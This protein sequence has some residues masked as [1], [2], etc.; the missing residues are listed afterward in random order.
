MKKFFLALLF[1]ALSFTL[2][3]AD[4]DNIYDEA[5]L[6]NEQQKNILEENIDALENAYDIDMV[7]L[8][9][10]DYYPGD[11]R[12][13]AAD[14]YDYGGFLSDGLI[15]SI[16]MANREYTIV[17]SGNIQDVFDNDK[18]DEILDA[19]A[20]PMQ[21]GHYFG[22]MEDFVTLSKAALDNPHALSGDDIMMI[23]LSAS[24]CA[25]IIT[26]VFV[27]Y[28][29]SKMRIKQKATKATAYIEPHSF[30]MAYQND[31]FLYSNIIRNRI[32]RSNSSSR[33]GSFRGSSGASHSGG[34]RGF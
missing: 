11:I 13:W 4:G 2:V 10:L 21:S 20:S 19:L 34:S 8:T 27:I 22:A 9:S 18:I 29:L 30:E 24:T 15:L 26:A 31:L 16:N 14:F 28:H 6:L 5:N 32:N 33:S 23:L 25:I 3:C 17:S 1:L 12:M 7:I